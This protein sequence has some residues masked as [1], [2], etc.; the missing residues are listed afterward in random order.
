MHKFM[1]AMATGAG[2]CTTAVQAREPKNVTQSEDPQ[3]LAFQNSAGYSDAVIAGGT[4][5]LSGLIATPKEGETDMKLAYE[6][7][8]ENIGCR[9]ERAGATWNDVVDITTYHTDLTG[10][11]NDFITVK[12]R[13]IKALFPVWTAIGVAS[14]YDPKGLVEMK[15]TAHKS[16]D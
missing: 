6:R 7:L 8:F 11:I 14:L 1:V 5:Y 4:I 2:L 12:H 15:I 13:Y 3:T 9:L 16:K 10:Q